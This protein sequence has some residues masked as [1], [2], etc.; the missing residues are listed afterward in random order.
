[1]PLPYLCLYQR[2]GDF[3]FWFESIIGHVNHVYKHL[4]TWYIYIPLISSYKTFIDFIAT[5]RK[6]GRSKE[7]LK[8]QSIPIFQY[9]PILKIWPNLSSIHI[10]FIFF[11]FLTATNPSTP[12]VAHP[13]GRRAGDL[14]DARRCLGGEAPELHD[15][16]SIKASG[17]LW[18]ICVTWYLC[19][20]T[21]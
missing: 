20:V 19:D 6:T 3:S 13:R 9:I 21:V 14:G 10:L 1:M 7:N 16:Q 2:A 5:P 4:I 8:I 11:V 12:S 15:V 17:A 18:M